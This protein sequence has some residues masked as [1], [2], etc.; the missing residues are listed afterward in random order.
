MPRRE[1]S[2]AVKNAAWERCKGLC[3]CCAT[4]FNGRRP[5]YDHVKPDGLAGEPT[6]ENCAV[7]CRICHEYKTH[8]EDRPVMAKADRQKKAEA[9]I[10]PK[11]GGFRGWRNFRGEAIW[12]D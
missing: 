9:G 10:K 4:P 6:L 8:K 5:Q 3:E 7:L 12:R 2:V 11:R 1:F